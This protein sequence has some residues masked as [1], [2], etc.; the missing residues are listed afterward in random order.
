MT[1]LELKKAKEEYKIYL[2]DKKRLLENISNNTFA[3]QFCGLTEERIMAIK[4]EEILRITFLKN[5]ENTEE[6]CNLIV[7]L[8][9]IIRNNNEISDVQSELVGVDSKKCYMNKS[10]I[11]SL[12]CDLE[13]NRPF[14]FDS[15]VNNGITNH[16][17]FIH[18]ETGPKMYY[19]NSKSLEK[20]T[21]GSKTKE[22]NEL[23]LYFFRKLLE[24]S[25][26][27]AI[28]KTLKFATYGLNKV[29]KR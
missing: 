24:F 4:E 7:F 8:D 3:K 22:F 9:D 28:E 23:Q 29:Y 16:I 26:E 1:D 15:K 11:Y 20:I 2:E 21:K 5:F 14:F 19:Y 13:N 27:E 17:F 10:N 12:Y 18:K 25:K 6:S